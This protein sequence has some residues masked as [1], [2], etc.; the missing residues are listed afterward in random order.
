MVISQPAEIGGL[1]DA[2]KGGRW[3]TAQRKQLGV[4]ARQV[5]ESSAARKAGG[6]VQLCFSICHRAC[7]GFP[8]SCLERV[9]KHSSTK[10]SSAT[11]HGLISSGGGGLGTVPVPQIAVRVVA[12][13]QQAEPHE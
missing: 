11:P 1:R 10:D 6:C 12:H 4:T 9:A 7:R 2:W 13:S 3:E 5:Y 8:L